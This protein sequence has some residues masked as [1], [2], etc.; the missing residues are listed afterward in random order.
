MKKKLT[1]KTPSRNEAFLKP[2]EPSGEKAT[3][4]QRTI[5]YNRG[6]TLLCRTMHKQ[7]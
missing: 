5:R 7:T 2:L 6:Q 4:S 3:L 1:I